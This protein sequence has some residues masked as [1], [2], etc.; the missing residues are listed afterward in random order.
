MVNAL[1]SAEITE[2]LT[3]IL[4]LIRS[5]DVST[6]LFR[7]SDYFCELDTSGESTLTIFSSS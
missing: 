2:L 5:F 7:V 3:E 4:L 1:L 6:T